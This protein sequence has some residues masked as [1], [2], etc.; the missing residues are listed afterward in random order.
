LGPVTP[1]RTHRLVLDG[2]MASYRWTI[3]GQTMH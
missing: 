1:H 2:D 3:N